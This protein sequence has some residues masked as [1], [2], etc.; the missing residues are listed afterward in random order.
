M[1]NDYFTVADE[2]VGEKNLLINEGLK[3]YSMELWRIT[4]DRD[5]VLSGKN[6]ETLDQDKLY[7]YYL[8]AKEIKS[9]GQ[10]VVLVKTLIK[11]GLTRALDFTEKKF[12][13]FEIVSYFNPQNISTQLELNEVDAIIN[14]LNSATQDSLAAC[15]RQNILCSAFNSSID[16]LTKIF[17]KM[18]TTQQAKMYN[19]IDE[20][21]VKPPPK[22][23]FYNRS[24]EQK[25]TSEENQS[26]QQDND[27]ND[28]NSQN[29]Q[30]KLSMFGNH[31]T[32]ISPTPTPPQP[33]PSTLIV[34]PPPSPTTV[35]MVTSNLKKDLNL[36][37]QSLDN[38][39][40]HYQDD[41]NDE[42][43]DDDDDEEEEY[44][45]E[46]GNDE[47]N[48]NNV[49]DQ[50]PLIFQVHKKDNIKDHNNHDDNY[51][52]QDGEYEEELKSFASQD[53][54]AS[55]LVNQQ[56][57]ETTSPNQLNDNEVFQQLNLNTS[58]QLV[59][60]RPIQIKEP[61]VVH[62]DNEQKKRKYSVIDEQAVQQKKIKK[63]IYSI[64]I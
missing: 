1:E 58:P 20:Q 40:T 12:P 47:D 53:S 51:D 41:T 32:L 34:T 8:A 48:D 49:I 57:E 36:L 24:S 16:G 54:L 35:P 55:S 64:N 11:M 15:V 26:L 46:N 33:S 2:E 25:Q 29:H 52:N 19:K 18:N 39:K 28:N 5:P 45:F 3:E 63:D 31:Q 43:D 61:N 50:G 44:D 22:T 7:K 37:V 9:K 59:L 30:P 56:Q 23:Y 6:F 62:V 13:K 27:D 14:S 38:N 4:I 10:T 42:D 21:K 60:N 17:E